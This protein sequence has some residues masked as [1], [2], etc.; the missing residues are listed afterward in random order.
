MQ[1]LDNGLFMWY[2]I[3]ANDNTVQLSYTKITPNL[4]SDEFQQ[5]SQTLPLQMD[6]KSL[7]PNLIF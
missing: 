7:N 4:S 6:L 3:R 5:N 2:L 1:K